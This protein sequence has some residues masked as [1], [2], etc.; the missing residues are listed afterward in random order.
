MLDLTYLVCSLN[1]IL[2]SSENEL[3]LLET[4]HLYVF[5]KQRLDNPQIQEGTD[6]SLLV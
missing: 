5:L 4:M 6:E 2:Y 3:E 1:E